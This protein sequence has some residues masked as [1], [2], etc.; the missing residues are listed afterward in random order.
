MTFISPP[1]LVVNLNNIITNYKIY[2]R[3]L[4]P[5]ASSAVVKANAYGVGVSQVARTLYTQANCKQFFVATLSEGIELRNYLGNNAAIYV[6]SGV[7]QNEVKEFDNFNL[8][9]V[10]N[11]WYQL[12]IWMSYAKQLSKKLP[13]VIHF[14]TGMNRLGFNMN[15][16]TKLS[17]NDFSSIDLRYVMS[18]LASADERES[19]QN[20][21]QLRQFQQIANKFPSTLKSFVNSAGSTLGKEYYYD[22]ARIGKGLYGPSKVLGLDH[23]DLQIAVSL[24]APILQIRNVDEFGQVGYNA[25]YKVKKDSTLATIG[26][27]YADGYLRSFS[28]RG[29]VYYKGYFLPVVGRVSMDYMVVDISQVPENLIHIGDMVEILG[30]NITYE[31]IFYTSSTSTYELFTRLSGRIEKKYFLNNQ[32]VINNNAKLVTKFG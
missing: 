30:K 9:P 4:S 21:F 17:E 7:F 18:H 31:M 2:E 13:A 12:E 29:R 20:R 25:T 15:D 8:I 24:N 32:E 23:P 11:D 26:I 16:A 6:F 22:L 5:T 3:I 10:L 14:D 27:G 28:N 1:E 19:A